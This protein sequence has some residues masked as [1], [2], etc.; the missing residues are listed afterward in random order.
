MDL[1]PTLCEIAG[2]N[3]GHEIDGQSLL[4][5]LLEGNEGGLNDRELIWGR[6][7][8]GATG[9][10]GRAYYAIRMGNWKLQH[11]SPFEPKQLFN[12][13]KAPFETAPV[14]N[15]QI[16]ADLG[17]RLMLHIQKAGEVPWHKPE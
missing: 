6:R 13:E 9:Y 11:S 16:A 15:R 3:I 1:Y 8:G 7:E 4:P 5:F 17:A 10:M 2:V 12:L 14:D